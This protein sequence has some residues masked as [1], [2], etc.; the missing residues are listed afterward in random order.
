MALE[1]LA[2]SVVVTAETTPVEANTTPAPVTT[3]TRHEI[4]Q[5]A[6]TSLPDLLA[7]LPGFSLDRTGPEGGETSLFLDGGNS[8]YTKVLVDGTPANDS[9]GLLDFSNFTLDNVEKIEVVHGAESA[10]YGSDAMTGVIQI[11]THRGDTR[12]PEL[13]LTGEGDHL[14]PAA[15]PPRSAGCSAL[16]ITPSRMAIS[17]LPARDLTTHF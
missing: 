4:E 9:G 5:R 15:A 7:T 11:F 1:P 2:S 16:W 12:E 13:D 6:A 8:N 14:I 17:L 3:I 10:V